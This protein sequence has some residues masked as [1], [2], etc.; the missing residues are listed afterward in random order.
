MPAGYAS[1]VQGSEFLG[2]NGRNTKIIRQDLD[3]AEHGKG[4]SDNDNNEQSDNVDCE[5]CDDDNGN[6]VN[7]A[8]N[9]FL[10]QKSISQLIY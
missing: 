1:S 7:S 5:H 3:T 6:D 10:L 2:S 4:N 9:S 8:E